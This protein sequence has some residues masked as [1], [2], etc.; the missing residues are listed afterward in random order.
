[1][2]ASDKKKLR[3]EQQ[4]AALTEKQ[5]AEQKKQKTLKSY[6]LTFVIAMVLVVAIVLVSVLQAPVTTLLMKNTNSLTVNDHQ[7]DSVEFNY[8][9]K[10]SISSFYNQFSSAGDY[11]NMYVQMY[12]GLNPAEPLEDQVYDKESGE[13]WAD[14]FIDDAIESAKWTYAI[15]DAAVAAGHKLTDD[16]KKSL[17]TLETTYDY[18]AMYFGY[19]DGNAYLKSM[20]GSS[21]SMDT[22]MEY[23]EINTMATSFASAFVEALDFG[24]KDFREHEKDKMQEYNTYSYAYVYLNSA[25]Y[26]TGGTTVKGEDGKETTT[27][28]DEEKKAAVELA[29]KDAQALAV[30]GNND[31][32]KLNLA[33]SKLT[34][35]GLPK[36]A[37]ESKALYSKLPTLEEMKE[38]ISDEKREAGDITYI[39]Y[40]THTHA[41]GEEHSDDEDESKHETVNGYYVVLYLDTIDNTMP[42]GTVRHL[43]VKWEL[44]N[45]KEEPTDKQKNDA[46]AEAEKLLK[47]YQDGK[48]TEEAFIELVKKHTDDT[49]SKSSG[50]L[51]ENIHPDAGYVESFTKWA[52]AEHKEGD[53]E[54][55][56]SEYGYHIMYY[57]EAA[58]LNY[59]DTLINNDLESE[60]YESWQESLLEKAKVTEGNM[61]FVDRDMVISH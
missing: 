11:Q 52:T 28:S 30:E 23:C 1:M 57:V 24:D 17:E 14:Y 51:I 12:T 61:K 53:V 33:I 35:K 36:E 19:Q 41:E 10:D 7:I 32:T 3:K 50:G 18:Y 15:Y 25:N 2:S 48:K 46:K 6:T 59:R 31:V 60:A 34:T 4:N 47:E 13:T 26:L 16:E 42:I 44:D 54:I 45:D 40:T 27:Y 9:Y 43:L 29:L 20:Y 5:Q 39:P 21:A 8:F 55:I 37:T 58:E 56:E 38:W 49:A 22:Y